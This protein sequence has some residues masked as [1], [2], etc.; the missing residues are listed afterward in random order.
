MVNVSKNL[1]VDQF[2]NM[3]NRI[4]SPHYLSF[5]E[6]DDKSLSHPHN[7]SLHIEVMIHRTHVRHVLIDGG[8]GLTNCSLSLL[9]TLGYSKKI[10]YTRRKIMIKASDEAK[11]S[12]KGLV[13]LTI[14]V[15]PIEKDIL[16]QTIDTRHLEY[17]F[18]LGRPWIH[19]M[20]VVS[21]TYHQCVKF[22][23]NGK[24]I[25]IL[26]DNTLSINSISAS[27]HVPLNREVD[28]LMQF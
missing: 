19:D 25:C 2:Q 20:K 11:R 23:Y 26:G 17:N 4:A 8:V 24:E 1:D 13:I 18:L 16:F 10:I 14:R 12:S 27:T 6:E 28:D 22:P 9:K 5:L 7:L 21:S 15:G 3:V